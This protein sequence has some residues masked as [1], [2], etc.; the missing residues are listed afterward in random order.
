MVGKCIHCNELDSLGTAAGAFCVFPHTVS[1]L[2]LLFLSPQPLLLLKGWCP[3]K[4]EVVWELDCLLHRKNHVS[5]FFL[6]PWGNGRRGE[7]SE[8]LFCFE[9]T[10]MALDLCFWD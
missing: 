10:A 6:V 2:S 8:W 1:F 3:E 5:L 7:F 9:S 4:Q